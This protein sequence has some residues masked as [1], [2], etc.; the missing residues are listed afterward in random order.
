MSQKNEFSYYIA[1]K[2]AICEK[3]CRID[4]KL[5]EEYGVKKVCAIKTAL[6]YWQG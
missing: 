1:E 2:A 5:Y 4:Q 6:V 3:N